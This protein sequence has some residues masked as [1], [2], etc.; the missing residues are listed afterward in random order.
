MPLFD[1]VRVASLFLYFFCLFLLS[2]AVHMLLS[3]V[4]ATC[5]MSPLPCHSDIASLADCHCFMA[6]TI[7]VITTI[8]VVVCIAH[9]DF[10]ECPF[11]VS[12]VLPQAPFRF[13]F[14]NNIIVWLLPCGV[15]V[16]ARKLRTVITE[17]GIGPISGPKDF[18]N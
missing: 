15:V 10:Y 1:C 7:V 14:A 3:S 9:S 2:T 11:F 12:L 6:I 16:I 4:V 18:R 17:C 13:L 5:N 8:V